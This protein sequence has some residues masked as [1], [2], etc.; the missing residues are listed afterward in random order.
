MKHNY[1]QEEIETKNKEPRQGGDEGT[2]K[3]GQQHCCWIG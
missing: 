2:E 3:Q 1:K